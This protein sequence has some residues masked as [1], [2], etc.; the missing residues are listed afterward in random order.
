MWRRS[1]HENGQKAKSLSRNWPRD[2]MLTP[3]H[4]VDGT[5]FATAASR[6]RGT[7]YHLLAERLPG[8]GWD[9]TAWRAGDSPG[10]AQHG[11]A[12]TAEAAMAAARGAVRYWDDSAH[13]ASQTFS[14]SISGIVASNSAT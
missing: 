7:R 5:L 12:P 10:N 1:L 3:W 8:D 2:D 11:C 9:W 14:R 4:N 6:H 13:P